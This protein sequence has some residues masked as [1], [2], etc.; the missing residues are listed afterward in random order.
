MVE[1]FSRDRLQ[2]AL[3]DR[4]IDDEPTAT[5]ESIDRRT[6]SRQ[7][8]RQSVLRDLTWLLNAQADLSCEPGLSTERA[9]AALRSVVNF[10]LPPMSGRLVSK[11][12]VADVERM[13]RDAIVTFEPRILPD[14]LRVQALIPEDPMGH[15]NC[16]SFEIVG[17]LWAQPYPL[18]LLL[19]TDIDLE[20]G[21]VEV[22]EDRHV[23][24]GAG[25]AR[26]GPAGGG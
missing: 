5:I 1:P 6:V 26:P 22:R 14:S 9:G 23:G 3:F 7:R 8:L 17:Q 13:V 18:E 24:F 4:L 15:H 25:G 20:T 10:G 2:P 19:K 12:E 11:L 16:I 21:M